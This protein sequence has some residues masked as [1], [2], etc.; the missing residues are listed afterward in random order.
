MGSNSSGLQQM[1]MPI[2]ISVQ[3][4]YSPASLIMGNLILYGQVFPLLLQT[5]GTSRTVNSGLTGQHQF[6]VNTTLQDTNAQGHDMAVGPNGDVYITWTAGVN[7][8][9]FYGRFCWIFAKSVNGGASYTATENIFDD[10]EAD[11]VHFNGWGIR[12]NGFPENC[13][14]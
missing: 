8:S 1:Q 6:V 14:R 5:E 4:I 7:V 13:S 10:N 12:T 3:L 11:Q 9:P 2:R